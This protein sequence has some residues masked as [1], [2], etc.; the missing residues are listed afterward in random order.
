[1]DFEVGRFAMMRS[2]WYRLSAYYLELRVLCRKEQYFESGGNDGALC[3][4]GIQVSHEAFRR[5]T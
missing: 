3:Y 5:E 4:R 2:A 1:M